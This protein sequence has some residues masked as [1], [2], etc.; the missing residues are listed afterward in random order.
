MDVCVDKATVP[1]MNEKAHCRDRT[2]MTL[3]TFTAGV[4]NEPHYV[5]F[6]A[7]HHTTFYSPLVRVESCDVCA[8]V[9]V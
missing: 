5:F 2:L 4:V 1:C 6:C 3:I 8:G 7:L 9:S